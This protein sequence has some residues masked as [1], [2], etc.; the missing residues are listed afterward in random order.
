M[1]SRR[2]FFS[3]M[4]IFIVVFILFQG[5]QTG[6]TLLNDIGL[7][8]NFRQTDLSYSDVMKY[9]EGFFEDSSMADIEN[10][11]GQI[12]YIGAAEENTREMLSEWAGYTGRRIYHLEELPEKSNASLILIEGD[13]LKDNINALESAARAETDILCMNLPDAGV[14]SA[15]ESLMNLLGISSVY[16]ESVTVDGIHLFSGFLLGGERIFSS[17]ETDNARQDLALEMPWYIV[18]KNTKTYMRGMLSDKEKGDMDNEDLPSVIWRNYYKSG[19]VYVVSGD[20]LSNRYIAMGILEAVMAE[21]EESYLYPVVNAQEFSLINSPIAADENMDTMREIYG[22]SLTRF[23]A[24]I[25]MPQLQSLFST[26]GFKPTCYMAPKYDYDD[27]S[28]TKD[29]FIDHYLGVLREAGGELGLSASYKGNISVKDKIYHDASYYA[30]EESGY[31]IHA[32]YTDLHDIEAVAELIQD[33]QLW[34]SVNTLTV[35]QADDFPVIG[36]YGYDMTV[37]QIT[38]DTL[39]HTFTDDLELMGLETALG[40]ENAALYMNEVYWPEDES[41]EWQNAYNTAS[42]NISTYNAPFKSFD[43]VTASESDSRIRE[44]LSLSYTSERIGDHINIHIDDYTG[45][46]W[47]VL[48]THNEG[49][50][51]VDGGEFEE[52]EE[53][54]YLITALKDDVD[55]SLYSV[56]EDELYPERNKK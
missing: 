54:A 44:Y 46:T 53:G 18:R 16:S 22:A 9:K 8:T 47:F 29:E 42:E 5:L 40:Y 36:Y 25:V 56:F 30:G 19:E 41:H 52:I 17:E 4:I 32:Y 50:L 31:K 27:P 49:I 7:N 23:E 43:R 12:I 34:E 33:H 37:R 3:I 2:R 15:D 14:I 28:V 6:R 10:D 24:D 26:Y 35:P 39:R 51:S 21:R 55:V 1:I 38:T 20:Y 11:G 13:Y 45:D 48:R